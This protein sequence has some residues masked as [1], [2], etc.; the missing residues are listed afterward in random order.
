MTVHKAS[1]HALLAVMV[2]LSSGALPASSQPTSP[3]L[4]P[5]DV[6]LPDAASSTQPGQPG[7][8]QFGTASD[9]PFTTGPSSSEAPQAKAG[10]GFAVRTAAPAV[11]AG[12]TAAQVVQ[13]DPLAVMQTTK[14]LIVIR[15]FRKFAPQTVSHFSTIAQTGFYNGLTFHRVVPGQIIEGGCPN[16]NGSGFYTDAATK[17]PRFIGLET[18][19]ALKHNAA[20]VVGLTRIGRSAFSSSSQFYITLAPQPTRDGLTSIFGGIVSGM[21]VVNQIQPGDKIISIQ[22]QEQP[23][24]QSVNGQQIQQ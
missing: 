5:P 4:V 19:T 13:R 20:G 21:D 23:Q 6:T 8:S 12:E 9:W 22:I 11:P 15:L 14:G 7:S 10:Q 16:G 3:E 2:A 18:S 24:E 17:K 1:A